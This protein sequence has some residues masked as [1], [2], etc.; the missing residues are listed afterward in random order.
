MQS[1]LPSAALY[2][3]WRCHVIIGST[4]VNRKKYKPED[5]ERTINGCKKTST[6][7]RT[8]SWYLVLCMIPGAACSKESIA[9]ARR[10]TPSQGKTL[11]Y[12]ALPFAAEL[13]LGLAEL[14]VHFFM[15][16]HGSGQTSRVGAGPDLTRPDPTRP[17]IFFRS[18]DPTRPDR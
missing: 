4:G 9:S 6:R 10:S 7:V 2:V 18:V 11:R 16:V 3:C 14:G 8:G 17:A 12:V 13:L 1:W 15:A 5:R